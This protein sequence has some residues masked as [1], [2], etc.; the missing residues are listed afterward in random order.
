MWARGCPSTMKNVFV[1]FTGQGLA[2]KLGAVLGCFLDK[3]HRL[4]S[5]RTKVHESGSRLLVF[6]SFPQFLRISIFFSDL[7][8]FGRID[9]IYLN[10]GGF[11]MF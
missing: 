7:S 11:H 6:C 10:V 4:L 5:R 2:L 8:G 1:V 3:K 9:A